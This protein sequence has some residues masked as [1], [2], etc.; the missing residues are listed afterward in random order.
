MQN[1]GVLFC[2][3]FGVLKARKEGIYFRALKGLKR[4]GSGLVF[5]AP[6]SDSKALKILFSHTAL[7]THFD[8]LNALARRCGL[9][10]GCCPVSSRRRC[11][12]PASFRWRSMQPRRW[13][14]MR[15]SRSTGELS[16][17]GG[18][19]SRV[20]KLVFHRLI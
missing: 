20:I 8:H 14:R 19:L 7:N 18:R 1:R 4:K 17:S 11:C 13:R 12:N 15:N 2:R 6:E 9:L 16:A 5:R 10:R 3:F